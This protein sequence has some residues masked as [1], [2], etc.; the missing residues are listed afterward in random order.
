MF[1]S[2]EQWCSMKFWI[3]IFFPWDFNLDRVP[4]TCD[5]RWATWN[6][7]FVIF[8]IFQPSSSCA[9]LKK[10][11]NI[12]M[13]FMFSGELWCWC[14]RTLSKLK[15]FLHRHFFHVV[16]FFFHLIMFHIL[17]RN[18]LLLLISLSHHFMQHA[19]ENSSI[20]STVIVSIN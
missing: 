7:I 3:L 14:C 4:T 5:G 8:T 1:I 18:Q 2:R 20:I 13:F 12:Y 11:S 9:E 19:I 6:I 17:L 16:F 10:Y 15:K